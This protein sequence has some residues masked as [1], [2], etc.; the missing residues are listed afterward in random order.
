MNATWIGKVGRV[1]GEVAP[2]SIMHVIIILPGLA[3]T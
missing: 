2:Q 1:D 3:Y